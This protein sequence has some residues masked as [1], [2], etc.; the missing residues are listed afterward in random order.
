[1]FARGL[2]VVFVVM[3]AACGGGSD[4]SKAPEFGDEEFGLTFK[5][6]VAKVEAVEQRIAE[7]MSDAGFEYIANDFDTVR[8]AMR[9][10]QSAPGLSESEFRHEFG[11]GISTQ[12]DKPIVSLGLGEDNS[13]IREGLSAADQV[14]Y[15]RTLLGEHREAVFANAL[16]EEDFSR[17]AGCTRKA[18][19]QEFTKKELSATY[20]NPGDQLTDQDPRVLEAF[21]KYADCMKRAGLDYTN[22]NDVEGDL[23]ERFDAVTGGQDPATLDEATAPGLADL[24]EFERRVAEIAF[25]CENEFVD[26]VTEAVDEEIYGRRGD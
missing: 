12:L 8:R 9:A 23:Q 26:P 11:F 4:S 17:T 19:Q 7:C 18:V 13:R 1:M 25:D 24:Q 22:P 5:E 15:D 20:L 16:E 10:G 2:A 3:L 14:A 21:E 6:L